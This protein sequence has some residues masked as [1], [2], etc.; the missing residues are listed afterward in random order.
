MAST[1]VETMCQ[2]N[3]TNTVAVFFVW[4]VSPVPWLEP[5]ILLP[6]ATSKSSV[7][8]RVKTRPTQMIHTERHRTSNLPLT[9]LKR[10][11]R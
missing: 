6:L 11:Q 3:C 10:F 8:I 4:V 1:N 9:R 2:E 5:S 7:Q